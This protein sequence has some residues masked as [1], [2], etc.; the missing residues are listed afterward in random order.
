MP[1]IN[2]G[3]GTSLFV[4][5]WG[6]GPPL[7]F[8]HAWGLRSDQ[9]D[10]QIPALTAAGLRCIVYDQRG[11]GRSDRPGRGY[12]LDTMADDL[13]AVIEYFELTNVTLVTHSVGGKEAVRYLTRHGDDRID[14]LVLIAPTTPFLRAAEDNPEGLDAALVDANYA[15]VAA[16]VPKWC[17]QF[18]AAGPYFGESA[19]S[20]PGLIEWTMQMII[21][22]PL[23]VLLETLRTNTDADMRTEVSKIDVPVLI[24]HGEQDAS[25]PLALT[26]RR[27][28]ALVPNAE[29]ITYPAA[30]HGVY[31]SDHAQ[32]NA[33]IIRF[34]RAI[35]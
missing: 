25:A 33:D 13:A 2:T 10:Y 32:V 18:E 5:D 14:K 34:V 8:V 31:A 3:D 21:D 11:H 16:D 30:G 17:R 9:W 22:T 29:L 27:T 20:S 7:V 35:A 6:S 19:G 15:A 12:D 28:A 24:L 1:F 23:M 4:T 26:G